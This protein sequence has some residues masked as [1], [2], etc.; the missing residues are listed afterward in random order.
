MPWRALCRIAAPTDGWRQTPTGPGDRVVLRAL[1][2]VL[3]VVNPCVDDVF[4]CS[5]RP[6]GG[7]YVAVDQ[8]REIL[9]SGAPVAVETL[10]IPIGEAA[11]ADAVRR[12]AVEH[13][14][15]VLAGAGT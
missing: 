13:A 2:D 4:G 9:R 6:G 8:P 14:L 12:R 10:V 3:V 5:A 1:C 7:V 11:A 15:A